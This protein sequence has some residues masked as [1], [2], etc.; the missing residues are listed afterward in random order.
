MIDTINPDN[1]YN[2]GGHFLFYFLITAHICLFVD[3][4]PLQ[5][6]AISK[7]NYL[8]ASIIS[9]T[10][11]TVVTNLTNFP[12]PSMELSTGLGTA[13]LTGLLITLTVQRIIKID[14][15]F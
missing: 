9:A 10:A 7:L 14:I 13:L 1:F 4:S 2:I 5:K 15:D 3:I 12:S 8:I 6:Y 11:P